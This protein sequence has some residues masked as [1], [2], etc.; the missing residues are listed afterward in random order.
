[1]SASLRGLDRRFRPWADYLLA[2]ARASGFGV[3]VTSGFR[4]MAEQ[5]RLYDL[6]QAGSHPLPVAPPG[7]SFHNYGL[8]FDAVVEY[9]PGGQAALGRFWESL[10][11]RWGGDRDPVHFSI[12]RGV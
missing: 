3:R 7:R 9:P 2:V 8:A 12:R 6:R 1:V 5:Q 11:G 4:S 10:G